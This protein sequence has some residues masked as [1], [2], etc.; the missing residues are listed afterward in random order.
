LLTNVRG[1]TA[2]GGILHHYVVVRADL[3]RGIQAAA[4][5]SSP[6]NLPSG[7]HVVVLTAKSEP[8]L[9]E[10]TRRLTLRGVRH[11]QIHEPDAPYDGALMAIGLTPGRKE[12]LRQHVSALPLLR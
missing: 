11:V 8:E 5:E 3:P 12:D 9:E 1:G 7:T 10:I 2:L 6:G 4:G